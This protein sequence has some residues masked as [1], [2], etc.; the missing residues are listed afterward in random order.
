M[1]KLASLL[2]PF[3][4]LFAAAP[5]MGQQADSLLFAKLDSMLTRYTTLFRSRFPYYTA[6]C[7]MVV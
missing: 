4:L 6:R 1:R 5:A 7:A 2:L 3:I